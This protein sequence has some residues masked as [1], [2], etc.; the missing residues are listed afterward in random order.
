[1][2]I[3]IDFF[4]G[5][6]LYLFK[7]KKIFF[8]ISKQVFKDLNINQN[9]ILFDCN[10]V[11]SKKIKKLN[12]EL[13]NKNYVTD[14]LSIAYWDNEIKTKLLGEIFICV[15]KARLQAKEYN[16]TFKR[17]ISFLFLHGLLHLL[18]YDHKNKEEENE[19]FCIQDKILD[20]LNI[21]RLKNE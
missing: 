2:K 6:F 17:E 11:S 1:M 13:R 10:L 5:S 16:H 3:N 8:K 19:M 15:K 20:K 14:V 12:N 4:F 7:Y 21:R 18:G 9:E